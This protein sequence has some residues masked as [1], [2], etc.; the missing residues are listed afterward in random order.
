MTPSSG[1]GSFTN[2][3]RHHHHS[4]VVAA[5]PA[6]VA[7]GEP[8]D[9]ALIPT[10]ARTGRAPLSAAAVAPWIGDAYWFTSSTSFAHPA[11][12][13]ARMFSD[14]FAGINPTSVPIFIL[15][16]I[17]DAGL[18]AGPGG[19]VARYLLGGGG[20]MR[21]RQ[22]RHPDGF[23][24]APGARKR[25]R[26]VRRRPRSVLERGRAEPIPPPVLIMIVTG[27]APRRRD[28]LG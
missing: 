12:T 8:T 1:P 10:L 3:D 25:A 20:R 21:T 18:G 11:V 14:T 27:M 23:A 4:P 19:R 15:F 28:E 16:R 7:G 17:L 6:P 24:H 26:R 5:G 22:T 13:I 2:C 9:F